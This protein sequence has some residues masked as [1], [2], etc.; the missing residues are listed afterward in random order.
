MWPVDLR[1]AGSV[2]GVRVRAQPALVSW[3]THPATDSL[4][5]MARDSEDWA[6]MGAETNLDAI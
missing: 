1:R 3:P 5:V 6:T 4:V 2:Q